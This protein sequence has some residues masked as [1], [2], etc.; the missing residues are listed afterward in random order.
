[1]YTSKTHS[2]QNINS[3]LTKEIKRLKNKTEIKLEIKRLKNK[4][5]I[6]LEI[7]RLKNPK[8]FID[9]LQTI[10]N[11]YENLEDY[12]PTKI[13]KVSLVLEDMIAD[14]ESN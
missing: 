14:V 4:T 9:Y 6:K 7:K 1:M 5:E 3:L 8:V 2:N 11:V 13:R 12:N 10:D